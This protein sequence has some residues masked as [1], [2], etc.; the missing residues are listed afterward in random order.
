LAD[1][2][3]AVAAPAVVAA[4]VSVAASGVAGILRR[5]EERRGWLRDM[6]HEKYSALIDAG[7]RLGQV[8]RW[9]GPYEEHPE[10]LAQAFDE[11]IAAAGA[12][13]F[14]AGSDLQLAIQEA[15]F[16]ATRYHETRKPYARF[17]DWV[18]HVESAARAELGLPLYAG[19][20]RLSTM[21]DE[22]LVKVDEEKPAPPEGSPPHWIRPRGDVSP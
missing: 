11:W 18:E 9:T 13:Q 12:A 4:V 14:L 8:M 20:R 21:A 2:T 17:H 7:R 15:R 3:T 19:W 22:V 6:R 1:W 16:A 10:P 5:R